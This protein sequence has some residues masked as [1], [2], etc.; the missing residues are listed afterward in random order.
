MANN[1]LFLSIDPRVFA[2]VIVAGM[3]GLGFTLGAIL[4]RVMGWFG[5]GI[6]RE[7]RD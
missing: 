3:A 6:T 7:G 5:L 4:D 2:L 1:T